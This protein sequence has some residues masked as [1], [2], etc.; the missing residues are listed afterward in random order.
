MTLAAVPGWGSWLG[1]F[2]YGNVAS[3]TTLSS[4]ILDADQEACYMVFPAPKAGYVDHIEFRV[5]TDTLDGTI[6][7]GF[8]GF[9]AGGDPDDTFSYSSTSAAAAITA[10]SWHVPGTFVDGGGNR[11]LV[12]KGESL[13]FV[14]KNT[15]YV[16]GQVVVGMLNVDNSSPASSPFA[17]S[18]HAGLDTSAAAWTGQAAWHPNCSIYYASAATGGSVETSATPIPG[19]F[20]ISTFGTALA[21]SDNVEMAG[22]LIQVDEPVTVDGLWCMADLDGDFT[23]RCYAGTSNT[24]LL[25]F[26]FTATKRRSDVTGLSGLYQ[27][28]T[29]I[30]LAAATN[31]RFVIEGTTA[32]AA[33]LYTLLVNDTGD[34]AA[35]PFGANGYLTVHNGAHPPTI[36]SFTDT[37]TTFPLMG[38]HVSHIHDGA[39]GSGGM[40]QSRVQV[41]M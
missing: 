23:L 5:G 18:I 22:I 2:P 9:A 28:F 19:V 27:S 8:M 39:G 33:T 12:T 20:A 1:A 14:V 38:L 13:C 16:S 26:A 31:Y 4:A 17:N 24:D 34:M 32:T 11:R 40:I 7:H 3:W 15:T 10:N 35:M 6:T 37:N 30:D 29:G 25:G 41:G 21:E 36:A